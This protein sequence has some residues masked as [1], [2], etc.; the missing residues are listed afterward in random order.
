[1]AAFIHSRHARSLEPQ[2]GGEDA[3]P[4][5]V[6]PFSIS[7]RIVFGEVYFPKRAAYYG[8]I[9]DALRFGH[10]EE[11]VREYLEG[12]AAALLEEFK[13]Y[14]GLLDP[15]QYEADVRKKKQLTVEDALARIAQYHSSFYGWST[16]S[17]DG[18]FFST[19]GGKMYEE[20]TQVV[21]IILRFVR[22]AKY[23]ALRTQAELAGCGD[24]LR[25]ILYWVITRLGRLDEEKKR[26]FVQEHFGTIAK[27][28][29]RWVD[30]GALF[31]FGY[32]VR[33]FWEQVLKE[34]L[35]EE[36]IWITSLFTMNVNVIKY[37][38]H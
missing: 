31:I 19:E 14:P 26:A 7:E 4:D 29:Q 1:M 6:Y 8:A 22:S 11:K 15:H 23:E 30:D 3:M 38:N 27:E 20:A 24:V 25:S 16:Y 9:F 5:I 36:E 10:Q 12:Q 17:V 2:K 21:R 18:V 28:A 35:S 13:G 32:L 34:G 37:S 33:Q